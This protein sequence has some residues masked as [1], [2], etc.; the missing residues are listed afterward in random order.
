MPHPVLAYARGKSKA[1]GTFMSLTIAATGA[2]TPDQTKPTYFFFFI[3][4][5]VRGSTYPDGCVAHMLF[6]TGSVAHRADTRGRTVHACWW[7]RGGRGI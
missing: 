6:Q 1:S 5:E 4:P 3:W 2:T 7:G